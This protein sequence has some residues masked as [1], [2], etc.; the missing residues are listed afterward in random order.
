MQARP[1]R[2]DIPA[3]DYT[4]ATRIGV[5]GGSFD[6]IHRGHLTLADCC[7]RQAALDLVVLVPTARQPLK[8]QGPVASNADRAAMVR[9]A[10]E[11]R[12]EFAMSMIELDRGGVSYT[13]D[14][15][16]EIRSRQ[17]NSKLFLLL[18]ADALTDFPRWREPAA[19]CD[20]AT[21]LVVRRAGH[22]APD[23]AA[24]APVASAE[25]LAEIRAAQVEMPDTPISSSHIRRL[26]ATGGDWQSLVPSDVAQYVAERG[27]YHDE[28]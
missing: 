4:M 1:A 24:L 9:A 17:P 2:C 13:V 8:P 6:P 27:L 25:R 26:I 15:L 16:R 12:P 14:T 21:L 10:I 28:R 18:G 20:L 5:F 3:P 19:I 11:G 23:F 22:A 7:R